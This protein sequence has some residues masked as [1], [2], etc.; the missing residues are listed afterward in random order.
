MNILEALQIVLELAR[1]NVVAKE[2]CPDEHRRQK[3]ALK[4]LETLESIM[5]KKS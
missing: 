4:L 2:D 1:Q 3:A 5:G